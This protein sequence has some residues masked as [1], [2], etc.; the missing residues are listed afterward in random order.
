MQFQK[1]W[2]H[3]FHPEARY[4]LHFRTGNHLQA[5]SH[6]AIRSGAKR[7]IINV[8][9]LFPSSRYESQLIPSQMKGEN[10]K[11]NAKNHRA[12]LIIT[13][14]ACESMKIFSFPGPEQL[15]VPWPQ[16]TCLESESGC[17]SILGVSTGHEPPG[18]TLGQL[19]S[20]VAQFAKGLPPRHDVCTSVAADHLFFFAA[21][22]LPSRAVRRTDQ[23]L[24]KGSFERA[25]MACLGPG[26]ADQ[27]FTNYVTGP[28]DILSNFRNT[29]EPILL[30]VLGPLQWGKLKDRKTPQINFFQ[31]AETKVEAGRGRKEKR[32]RWWSIDKLKKS[33]MWRVVCDKVVFERCAWQNCVCVWKIVCDQ[34]V[35][36]TKF[37]S[38]R[39]QSESEHAV[40][41]QLASHLAQ[42]E[43]IAHCFVLASSRTPGQWGD[44]RHHVGL[45][46]GTGTHAQWRTTKRCKVKATT[47]A[48]KIGEHH[49]ALSLRTSG[50]QL[51][52]RQRQQASNSCFKANAPKVKASIQFERHLASHLTQPE[53]MAHCS[54]LSPPANEVTDDIT[55]VCL[56]QEHTA[57]HDT[58]QI[59]H[60]RHMRFAA[61]RMIW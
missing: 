26:M 44:R 38:R 20:P 53:H 1:F 36:V 45:L 35:C 15:R 60:N 32:R 30:F 49:A 17:G 29:C 61:G 18:A 50:A 10:R 28:V 57:K 54:L 37:Q 14:M 7:H 9:T 31:W 3:G 51:R 25:A 16:W 41:W 11:S 6:L 39:T 40:W 58:N 48:T 22:D 5:D 19:P 2:N 12:S 34:V 33:C 56:V 55:S 52:N 8:S 43:H 59:W 21:G 13:M 47:A 46:L 4:Q 27:S 23:Y 24:I 42:P